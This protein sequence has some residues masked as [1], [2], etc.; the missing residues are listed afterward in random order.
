MA[1]STT[2]KQPTPGKQQPDPN[3]AQP[4]PNGDANQDF[5]LF[6]DKFKTTAKL[7]SQQALAF[8]NTTVDDVKSTI[9]S[10][11]QKQI[12][13]G[14]QQWI[15]RLE[16]FLSSMEQYGKVIEVFLNASEVLAFIWGPM[17]FILQIASNFSEVLSSLLD[18]Y[19]ELGELIPQLAAYRAHCVSNEY[20]RTV[21]ALIYKDILE[22]H[23]CAMKHFRKPMWKQMFQAVWRGFTLKLEE[24]KDNM[25]RH[26]HLVESQASIVLFEETQ[27][28][29]RLAEEK[30]QGL[31]NDYLR[32]RLPEVMRWLSPYNSKLQHDKCTKD[33]FPGSGE[34]LLAER[35]FKN[36]FDP[37]FCSTPLLWLNGIPGAGKTVLASTI[38]DAV[39]GLVNK[40]Q[41]RLAYFYCKGTND[42]RNNFVAVARGLL[43]QLV[44]GDQDLLL[45]LYEKGNL[46]SGEAILRDTSM[47]KEL[48]DVALDSDKTTYII[49]DGI[50]ECRRE[51]RKEICSWF[52]ER[53]N[54]LGKDDHGNIRCL[55][56]SQED[57]IAKKDLVMVPAIK[58]L[59]THVHKDIRRYVD[60]WRDKIELKHG[61]LDPAVHPLTD[62]IMSSARGMFLFAKL[63]VQCLYGMPTR[64]ELLA[65]IQPDHFPDELG[66]LYDAI[67]GRIMGEN[68]GAPSK[69]I[70]RLLG[71]LAVAKRPLRWHEIQGYFAFDSEED[72]QVD[73]AMRKLRVDPKD[74]CWSLVEHQEDDSVELVHPTAR[75]HLIRT[76]YLQPSKVECD[77]AQTCLLFLSTDEC[78]RGQDPSTIKQYLMK[79]HYSFFEYAVAC[80][81]LHLQS[82]LPDLSSDEEIS[83]LGECLESFLTFHWSDSRTE[84]TVS[85]TI[86][87]KIKIFHESDFSAKLAQAIVSSRKQLGPDGA[88]PS[89][90]DPLDLGQV[91]NGVR[92]AMENA[93]AG[94]DSNEL[95]LLRTYYG[96]NSDWF[97]CSRTNCVRFY[98]GFARDAE[99]ALHV[100]KHE[101]PYRCTDTSCSMHTFGYGTEKALQR[102]LVDVHGA[103][104]GSN[105]MMEFPAPP[106]E[107]RNATQGHLRCPDCPKAFTRRINLQ[108]HMRT[109][110]NSKPFQ[111]GTC[112]KAFARQWDRTRHEAGH[113]DKKYVCAGELDDGTPWG[114]NAGFARADK[115][116]D[117][118]RNATG[119]RCIAARMSEMESKTGR[120][121]EEVRFQE[122]FSSVVGIV[123]A[124]PQETP[125]EL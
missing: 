94:S 125:P 17:K 56:V 52:S 22:F 48:L 75:S 100:E 58:I 73:H 123:E 5:N 119:R 117:H 118:L 44:K 90:K 32:Q 36:W 71:L 99:R 84:L 120:E 78:G 124:W 63:V 115:L 49:I 4:V 69:T 21:L 13:S 28:L 122:L 80:W 106:K 7:T 102:H 51:E 33:K 12:S 74:L 97:K 70:R 41:V 19:F 26:R 121:A 101:R 87:E 81:S 98:A 55:F 39:Q 54:K 27:T 9:A 105:I 65:Q 114:C 104:P 53:V 113:G 3:K 8:Q 82:A 116:Q 89:L 40:D 42:T 79:G 47:A 86:M 16:P 43:S 14:R 64:E 59:P 38:I 68:A 77:L 67:L 76:K 62:M 85:A 35:G 25:R 112:N 83:L 93:V 23:S 29:R 88:G 72:E 95:A 24:L 91:T 11:Q 45:Q 107:T 6:L 15:R 18:A 60:S 46:Q 34:W 1:P 103:D 2:G 37:F 57:G 10:I 96:K 111:C 30:F 109:H 108:S 31:Q 110:E 66:D 50:D 92:E 20:M 61:Q